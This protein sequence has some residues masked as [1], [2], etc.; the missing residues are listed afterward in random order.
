[1]W[2]RWLFRPR[3]SLLSGVGSAAVGGFER[4]VWLRFAFLWFGCFG[5]GCGLR[6][7]AGFSFCVAGLG[8]GLISRRLNQDCATV[9]G[10]VSRRINQNRAVGLGAVSR[11]FDEN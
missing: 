5:A 7:V 2:V 3:W 8:L 9:S 1:M 6:C 10:A 11:S 4:V